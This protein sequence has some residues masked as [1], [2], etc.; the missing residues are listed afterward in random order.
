VKQTIPLPSIF[1]PLLLLLA[2]GGALAERTFKW[3]DEQGNVHYGDRVP[4]QAVT[5]HR[6]EINE[7]G[8]TLKEYPEPGSEPDSATRERQARLEMQAQQQAQEQER[9][10]RKLLASYASETDLLIARDG[11]LGAIEEFIRMTNMR[12]DSLHTRLQELEADAAAYEGHGKPVPDFVSQQ[13]AQIRDQIA[14]NEAIITSRQVELEKRNAAYAA[15]I[16]RYQELQ[17]RRQP[18]H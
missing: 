16:A 9:R 5:Q 1:L 2:A 10:D 11:E 8:R 7:Q 6:Q 18:V 14:Q 4:M 12:I 17:S 13:M 3:V 15:D